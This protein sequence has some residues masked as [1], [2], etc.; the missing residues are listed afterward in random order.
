HT[1]TV[2]VR[3]TDQ[4][5]LHGTAEVTVRL[6]DVNEPPTVPAGQVVSVAERSEVGTS[7]GLPVVAHDPDAGDVLSF[8][9]RGRA[10]W[11][12]RSASPA[13]A[14]ASCRWRATRPPSAPR[15]R[16]RGRPAPAPATQSL[17]LRERATNLGGLFDETWVRANIPEVNR[18][19]EMNATTCHAGGV[20]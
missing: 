10:M 3:A 13:P 16:R 1:Y 5:G 19:P 14:L 18:A 11:M 4:D 6:I 17:L 2:H 12:A 7:V 8:S 15:R 20:R 9:I